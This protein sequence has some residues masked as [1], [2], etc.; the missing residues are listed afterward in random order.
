MEHRKISEHLGITRKKKSETVLNK[1]AK[2]LRVLGA[3]SPLG[4]EAWIPTAGDKLGP[5]PTVRIWAFSTR[6]FYCPYKLQ[7]TNIPP[8]IGTDGEVN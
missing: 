4:K 7:L 2:N 3:N 5:H 1:L 8:N 6:L